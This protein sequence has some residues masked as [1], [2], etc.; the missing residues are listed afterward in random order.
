MGL[1]GLVTLMSR[2]A[3]DFGA[4]KVSRNDRRHALA[5][6]KP[7]QSALACVPVN[8]KQAS[9]SRGDCSKRKYASLALQAT[10]HAHG[11]SVTIQ[12]IAPVGRGVKEREIR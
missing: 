3:R 2:T 6:V 11:P 4:S 8:A 10:Y 12:K 1:I 5:N 9:I 7:G